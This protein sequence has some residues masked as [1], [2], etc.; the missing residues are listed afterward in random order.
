MLSAERFHQVIADAPLVSIDLVVTDCQNRLLL[1]QRV[2]R[3]AQGFW[4]VPG[5]RI[6]KGELLADAMRRLLVTELGTVA[7]SMK[8]EWL[9]LYEHHYPDS[10]VG[11]HIP[12]HYVVLAH[13]LQWPEAFDGAL[14]NEQHTAYRWQAMNEVAI[15]EDVHVHTR[16]YAQDLTGVARCPRCYP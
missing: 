15:A 6:M 11:S 13:T 9:G 12:T 2:N 5:G 3:P 7:S 16:W 14:P 1:G 8:P 4:F 10:M